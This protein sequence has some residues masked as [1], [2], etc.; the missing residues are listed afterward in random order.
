MQKQA[1]FT[2]LHCSLSYSLPSI[3]RF[4]P[5]TVGSVLGLWRWFKARMALKKHVYSF[6]QNIIKLQNI[7]DAIQMREY[8]QSY[9]ANDYT[10][11]M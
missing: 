8:I 7:D 10:V 1:R 6:I 4:L 5:V 2:L 3:R 11:C 9:I